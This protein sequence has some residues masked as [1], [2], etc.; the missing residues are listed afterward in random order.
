MDTVNGP[1]RGDLD[2]LMDV[3]RDVV[4]ESSAAA[5]RTLDEPG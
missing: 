2:R 3:L 5:L 1:R 4:G